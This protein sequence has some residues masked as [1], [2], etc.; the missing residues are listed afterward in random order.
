MG[1]WWFLR[2][3]SRQGRGN[4]GIELA[5]CYRGPLVTAELGLERNMGEL[6]KGDCTQ[7]LYSGHVELKAS[8]EFVDMLNGTLR[9]EEIRSEELVRVPPR[10]MRRSAWVTRPRSRRTIRRS[11]VMLS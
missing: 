5:S 11:L 10:A 4:R 3:R 8:P 7:Y 9:V 2:L 6:S 1:V